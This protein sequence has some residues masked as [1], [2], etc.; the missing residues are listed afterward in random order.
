MFKEGTIVYFDPF[1]FQNGKSA[2]KPKYCII[3][4][5]I[6][7]TAVIASLP[8]SK[9]NVPYGVE[10]KGCIEIE[11]FNFN[12]FVFPANQ[13][14]TNCGKS[15]PLETFVYG[16]QIDSYPLSTWADIYQNE[17][18]D[19]NVFGM[20]QDAIYNDLISCLKNSKATKKKYTKVL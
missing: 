3:L 19:Y 14:V 15:F 17:G 16:Y 11:S 5:N 6:D 18:I 1:Y 13:I 2:P 8:T 12:A 4:K 20:L 7:D 9:D 10:K